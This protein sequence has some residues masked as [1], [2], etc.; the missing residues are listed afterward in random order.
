[1]D[2]KGWD[3]LPEEANSNKRAERRGLGRSRG[4]SHGFRAKDAP[5]RPASELA[6]RPHWRQRRV[7]KVPEAWER[8][9][10]RLRS[11]NDTLA[12]VFTV[13]IYRSAGDCVWLA[14]GF[15]KQGDVVAGSYSA[16]LDCCGAV[17]PAKP[18]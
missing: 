2:L 10:A 8:S 17:V 3:I 4:R 16:R 11:G 15:T 14:I 9:F 7:L 18:E 1:M 5:Y 13:P 6:G 12:L